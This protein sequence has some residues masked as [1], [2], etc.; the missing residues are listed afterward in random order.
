LRNELLNR[1]PGVAASLVVFFGRTVV[2]LLVRGQALQRR[3]LLGAVV[4][5][6]RAPCA[7]TVLAIA[8]IATIPVILIVPPFT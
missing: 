4:V 2:E 1:D 7:K 5:R 3:L 6:A 8:S